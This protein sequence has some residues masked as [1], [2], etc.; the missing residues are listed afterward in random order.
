MSIDLPPRVFL[1]TLDQLC[2]ILEVPDA[3]LR[4][5]HLYF[6][7]RSIGRKPPDRM[8]AVNLVEDKDRRPDW[9]VADHELIRWLKYK[10][11][12]YY[13]RGWVRQ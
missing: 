13:E 5:N 10:G 9:R 7:G 11:F 12:R 8:R 1:Y 6:E 2:T 3:S 4:K